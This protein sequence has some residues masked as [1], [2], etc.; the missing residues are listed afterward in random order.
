MQRLIIKT[1]S[2]VVR[3]CR[4]FERHCTLGKVDIKSM[5]N[6]PVRRAA[7]IHRMDGPLSAQPE[8]TQRFL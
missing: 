6:L 3:G 1:L 2:I 8:F 7:G 4:H 5:P